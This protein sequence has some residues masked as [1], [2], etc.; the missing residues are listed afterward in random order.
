M[1][2]HT[3]NE[4]AA[5]GYS[6][7]INYIADK[8]DAKVFSLLV[9]TLVEFTEKEKYQD[10]S[11]SQMESIKAINENFISKVDP[12]DVYIEL[13]SH[14]DEY[15]FMG[16]DH[17]WTGLGAYRAYEAFCDQIGIESIPL[18][19][20][21]RVDFEGYLGSLYRVSQSE[22]LVENPDTLYAYLPVV[23]T[24]YQINRGSEWVSGKVIDLSFFNKE[25][26]ESAYGVYLQ[27]DS[28][29]SIITSDVGTD[30]SIL[31]IKDSYANAVIPFLT[32]HY[33]SIHIIDP[34]MYTGNIVDYINEEQVDE[35]LFLN[36]VL[37]NRFTGYIDLLNTLSDK[38]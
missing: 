18:E 33:K 3:L 1:E 12:I 19:A 6:E 30:R 26:P 16:T 28:A 8:V 13:E 38:F 2:I 5:N 35:V 4:D 15:I 9:P 23:D 10:I 36:Y 7:A 11:Y 22:K 31:I 25:T 20:F 37:V 34:R 24:D 21:E 14:K 17:H 29:L 32:S 27:G